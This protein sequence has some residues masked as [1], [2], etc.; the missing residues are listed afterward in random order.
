MA[1]SLLCRPFSVA[2][3]RMQM[4][5]AHCLATTYNMAMCLHC[6]GFRSNSSIHCPRTHRPHA[7]SCSC[8]L[9]HKVDLT[10]CYHIS[11]GSHLAMTYPGMHK[12]QSEDIVFG[13]TPMTHSADRNRVAVSLLGQC[14]GT[15]CPSAGTGGLGLDRV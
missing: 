4:Q 14:S 9:G 8:L 7:L 6:A 13:R 3:S 1:V 2:D 12:H 15:I 11:L 10:H 5:G